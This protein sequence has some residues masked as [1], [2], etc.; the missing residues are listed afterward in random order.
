[1]RRS[2]VFIL[3][4]ALLLTPVPSVQ[5]K[6]SKSKLEQFLDTTM[7]DKEIWQ[8]CKKWGSKYNVSPFLIASVIETESGGDPN[9]YNGGCVGLMQVS[10]YYN[11]DR[12]K[13]LGV[14]DFYSKS[15]N[16]KI[17]THLLAELLKKY[18]KGRALMCYN[19]GEGGASKVRHLT[20]YAKNIMSREKEIKKSYKKIFKTTKVMI[21]SKL[22]RAKTK[23]LVIKR[24]GLDV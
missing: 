17:G 23:V 6:S 8:A 3:L 16:V 21:K 1:M 5:A 4:V 10:V 19:M 22:F 9:A 12:A 15:G 24:F 7:L 18:D 14:A 20:R 11:K 13:K 2:L